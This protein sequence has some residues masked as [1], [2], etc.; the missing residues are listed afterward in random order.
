MNETAEKK[1]VAVLQTKAGWGAWVKVTV[2]ATPEADAAA[3]AFFRRACF[4]D[5]AK[6]GSD[7]AVAHVVEEETTHLG[8]AL[9]DYF[10]PT[11]EHGMSLSLCMGPDHFPSA[12]QE[13]ALW[14]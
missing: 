14:G 9:A 13:R 3:A 2:A 6:G 10:F 1:T 8:E 4:Y 7:Y 12:E 11:C 5:A